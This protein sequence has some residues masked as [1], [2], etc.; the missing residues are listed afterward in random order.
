M[1]IRVCPARR[2]TASH[3]VLLVHSIKG[4]RQG[5]EGRSQLSEPS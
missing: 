1:E 5:H 4:C 2:A 3:E